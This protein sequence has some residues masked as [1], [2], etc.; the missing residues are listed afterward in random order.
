MYHY[1]VIQGLVINR[2]YLM[3]KSH[4][5]NDRRTRDQMILSPL[6][7]IEG[8]IQGWYLQNDISKFNSYTNNHDYSTL[9][10]VILA[11]QSTVIGNNM[12]A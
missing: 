2:N 3:T 10:F 5:Q 12:C 1:L 11:D 9:Y 7:N 6:P 4:G 8:H